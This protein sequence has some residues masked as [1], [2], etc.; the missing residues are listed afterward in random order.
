MNT[1]STTSSQPLHSRHI[2]NKFINSDETDITARKSE[3]KKYSEDI[4]NVIDQLI[5]RVK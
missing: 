2:D 3:S 1:E 5:V 4:I